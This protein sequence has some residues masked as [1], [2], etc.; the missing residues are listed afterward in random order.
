MTQDVHTPEYLAWTEA[1]AADLE[2]RRAL[3]VQAVAAAEYAL[4]EARDALAEW[5]VEHGHE[6]A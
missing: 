5:E 3:L 1:K 4:Q 2:Q 6:A